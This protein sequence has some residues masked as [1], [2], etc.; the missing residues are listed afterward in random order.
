MACPSAVCRWTDAILAQAIF[1][2]NN[3]VINPAYKFVWFIFNPT[4]CGH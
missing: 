3:E 4:A 1:L 2:S